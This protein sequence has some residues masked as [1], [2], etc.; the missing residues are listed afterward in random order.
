MNILLDTHALL[1]WW[2]EPE[3]LS[4]RVRWILLDSST[5]VS[6]SAASA[7]EIA[8]KFRIGKLPSGGRIIE[9]W[10]ESIAED[11]FRELAMSARHALRAV[12]SSSPRISI[13]MVEAWMDFRLAFLAPR[14]IAP[15]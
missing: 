1:W 7:W 4:P 2:S 8:R 3:K 12:S 5:E 15:R 11:R 13:T 6:V 9:Q 10:M 14:D